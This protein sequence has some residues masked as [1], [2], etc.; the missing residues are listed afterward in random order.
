MLRRVLGLAGTVLLGGALALAPVAAFTGEMLTVTKAGLA[1]V[2]LLIIM[3][4][5]PRPPLPNDAD[6]TPEH[7]P[8]PLDH[9]H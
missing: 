5:L 2:A 3:K 8:G 9:E 1:G 7:L 6:S 4:L